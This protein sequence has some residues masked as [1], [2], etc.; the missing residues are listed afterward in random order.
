MHSRLHTAV[1]TLMAA[2]PLLGQTLLKDFQ[3][4]PHPEVASSGAMPIA[5]TQTGELLFTAYSPGSGRELWSTDGTPTG[6]QLLADVRPGYQSSQAI[7]FVTLPSGLIMFTARTEQH[8]WELWRTDGTTAG[9]SLVKDILPGPVG[10]VAV[11]LTVVGNGVVFL[12]DDGV[13]GIEPWKSDGTTAGTMMIADTNPFGSMSNGTAQIAAR[14]PGGFV[15]TAAPGQQWQ[16]WTSDGTAGG[17]SKIV[18]LPASAIFWPAHLTTFGSRVLFKARVVGGS[19]DAWVTDGTAAGT[20]PLGSGLASGFQVVG[21]TAYFSSSDLELWR[22][23]GTIVGTQLVVDLTPGTGPLSPTRPAFLGSIGANV[24]FTAFYGNGQDRDLF[25]SDGTAAGTMAIGTV[26]TFGYYGADGATPIGGALYFQGTDLGQVQTWRTDGTAA[27]TTVL[28]NV[29]GDGFVER[30]AMVF[31]RAS[32]AA[33]GSELWVSDGTP[34]G[35]QL[36]LDL[37]D[38]A[39]TLDSDAY[40]VTTHR[41]EV[42]L[43]ADDG[44]SGKQLWLTDGTAAGTRAMSSFGPGIWAARAASTGSFLFASIDG[45]GLSDDPWIYRNASIGLQQLP[46]GATYP[47]F[48]AGNAVAAGGQVVFA[49]VTTAGGAEPWISDG[50]LAGTRPIADLVPGAG[51]SGPSNFW[52]WRG[53]TFFRANTS[54]SGG[55]PWVTDGTAAGTFQLAE[56]L[57][58]SAGVL[59]IT[60]EAAGDLVYFHAGSS[61]PA[62]LDLWVTNGTVAGTSMLDVEPGPAGSNPRAMT[63][64][65][66]RMLFAASR[67]GEERLFV[68][69]GSMAGTQLLPQPT[70]VFSIE[71]IADDLALV[72]VNQN[73]EYLGWRSDGTAAGTQPIGSLPLY[74]GFG[75][76]GNVSNDKLV[77][78]FNDPVVGRELFVTDGT[79][80]GTQLLLDIGLENGSP[81]QLMRAGT[82][83][84]AIADDGVHGRELHGFDLGAMQDET[85]ES[86]GFGC[87]GSGGHVPTLGVVGEADASSAVPFDLVV[88]GTLAFAP[89]LVALGTESVAVPFSGCTVF[90]GGSLV[91][92]SMTANGLGRAS[93]SLQPMPSLLGQRFVMQAFPI[94]PGAPVLGLASATV[95]LEIIF[96]P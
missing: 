12:A 54:A 70:S 53:K 2:S 79:T 80:A 65:A 63:P 59:N 85:V 13:H 93:M 66:D 1:F 83:L 29:V 4:A 73:G 95:G 15:F 7:Q 28:S 30:N 10:S 55:E 67:S 47:G 84:V 20:F 32:D 88:D 52:H 24:V 60:F 81:S 75:L 68:T 58:G 41:D 44:V 49:G 14:G 31:F 26:A 34:Q 77:L 90:A 5:V 94:D 45:P 17:T 89:V 11:E 43:V 69:D 76:R 19:D 39:R 3:T 9:T 25:V 86:M 46:V 71:R 16:L 21:T 42:A 6:T 56:M 37:Y 50:T 61:F 82:R 92:G 91:F 96:G 51:H 62:A 78:E 48:R 18:D 22:T 40:L 74:S 87:A 33:T 36:F 72:V 64:V 8:G 38:S 27:G 35:T 57:P 23:D